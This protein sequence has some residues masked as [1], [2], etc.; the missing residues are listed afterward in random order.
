LRCPGAI[1][2]LTLLSRPLGCQPTSGGAASSGNPLAPGGGR[3][4]TRPGP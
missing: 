1:V 3:A 2:R 4:R